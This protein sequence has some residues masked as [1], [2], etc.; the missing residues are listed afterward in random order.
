MKLSPEKQTTRECD[1]SIILS[2]TPSAHVQAGPFVSATCLHYKAHVSDY[3]EGL[4]G[5]NL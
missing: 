2:R 3:V 1:V 5:Y 4:M